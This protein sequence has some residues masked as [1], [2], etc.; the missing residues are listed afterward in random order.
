MALI[1]C[2]WANISDSRVKYLKSH[3]CHTI[4]PWVAIVNLH[5]L[6]HFVCLYISSE[7]WLR[8]LLFLPNIWKQKGKKSPLWP[9]VMSRQNHP[10]Y[11]QAIRCSHLR[12][13]FLSKWCSNAGKGWIT[14]CEWWWPPIVAV[15]QMTMEVSPGCNDVQFWWWLAIY[16]IHLLSS[17]FSGFGPWAL[18]CFYSL[19]PISPC[20]DIEF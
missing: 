4:K 8:K 20:S 10:A 1:F 13:V 19:L 5:L 16:W 18:P 2:R 15:C 3:C 9:Q 11:A 14:T 12:L 7:I 17:P 6:E